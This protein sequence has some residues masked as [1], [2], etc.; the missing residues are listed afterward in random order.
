MTQETISTNLR[1]HSLQESSSE[2]WCWFHH[3]WAARF[4]SWI[5]QRLWRYFLLH[6]RKHFC[7]L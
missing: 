1:I 7:I 5:F 3:F 6:F 2:T 4:R